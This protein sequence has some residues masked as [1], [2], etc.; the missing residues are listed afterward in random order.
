MREDC[1]NS[2]CWIWQKHSGSLAPA[3]TVWQHIRA[4]P[5]LKDGDREGKKKDKTG[6]LNFSCLFSHPLYSVKLFWHCKCWSCWT[7]SIYIY[8]VGRCFYLKWLTFNLNIWGLMVLNQ[9][10]L[11][12]KLFQ[13]LPKRLRD[14]SSITTTHLLLI[15][16]PCPICVMLVDHYCHLYYCYLR[17]YYA[18][19]WDSI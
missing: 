18:L 1:E 8:S 14:I 11:R 4:A 2:L 3:G 16:I 13:S 10:M 9:M 12:F 15:C 7:I 17:L 5:T 6:R 19:E